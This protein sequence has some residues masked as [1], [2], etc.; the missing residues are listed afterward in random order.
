MTLQTYIYLGIWLITGIF[1]AGVGWGAAT[2]QNRRT[3]KDLNGVGSKMNGLADKLAA[4]DRDG[5]DRY[6]TQTVALMVVA[7][8]VEDRELSAH[9]GEILNDP[10]RGK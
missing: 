3:R 9:V 6:M 10:S 8:A 4:L 1:S 2:V 5:R 7:N